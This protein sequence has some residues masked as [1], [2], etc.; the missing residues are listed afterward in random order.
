[1]F[2]FRRRS[3]F[4][5]IG[6]ERRSTEP[7]RPQ[8]PYRYVSDLHRWPRMSSLFDQLALAPTSSLFATETLGA[9]E[10]HHRHKVLV[11]GELRAEDFLSAL[12]DVGLLDMGDANTRLGCVGSD[13]GQTDI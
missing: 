11:I 2:L 6:R 3:C 8:L 9:R 7:P 10:F 4:K 5:G 12:D 13:A 1:M